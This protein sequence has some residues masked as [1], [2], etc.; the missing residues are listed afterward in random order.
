MKN[1]GRYPIW[2]TGTRRTY[3]RA[4]LE[5]EDGTYWCKWYGQLIAINWGDTGTF[6]TVEKY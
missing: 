5:K 2:F 4:V 6:Y 1:H 3:W